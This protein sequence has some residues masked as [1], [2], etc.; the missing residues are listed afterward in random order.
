MLMKLSYHQRQQIIS[1]EFNKERKLMQFSIHN[2]GRGTIFTSHR[3]F[4]QILFCLFQFHFFS[5]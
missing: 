2:L 3:W 5:S 4:K 1:F